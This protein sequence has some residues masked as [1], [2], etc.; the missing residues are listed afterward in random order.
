MPRTWN[1]AFGPSTVTNR[2]VGG[3]HCL[4]DNAPED[5]PL[6]KATGAI[7]PLIPANR[8]QPDEADP[9]V[10][11]KPKHVSESLTIDR[12]LVLLMISL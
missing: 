4:F 1:L 2:D 5:P 9:P 12:F 11:D 6:R 3:I 10:I 8:H 7:I